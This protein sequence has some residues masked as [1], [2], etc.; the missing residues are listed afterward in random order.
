LGAD[1][2]CSQV[3][4]AQCLQLLVTRRWHQSRREQAD[5]MAS[6]WMS[7]ELAR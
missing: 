6:A 5:A 1:A 2:L 7:W 3:L 4:V